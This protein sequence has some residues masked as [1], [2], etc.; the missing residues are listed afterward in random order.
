MQQKEKRNI[1]KGFFR[2][3][4]TPQVFPH[5]FGGGMPYTRTLA[6]DIR[7]PFPRPIDEER[8]YEDFEA[9][10]LR[11]EVSDEELIRRMGELQTMRVVWWIYALGCLVAS[12]MAGTDIYIHGLDINRGFVSMMLIMLTPPLTGLFSVMLFRE[13]FHLW[14][15][16]V[17]DLAGVGA[18]FA[19]GGLKMMLCPWRERS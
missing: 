13:T 8:E 11:N 6:R 17:R 7:Q 5:E 2:G 18:F 16:Q 12:I 1:F 3:M 14:Q 15:C 19:D 4:V 9:K 10:R